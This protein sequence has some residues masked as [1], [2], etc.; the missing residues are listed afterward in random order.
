[1]GDATT[2]AD[3]GGLIGLIIFALF[4]TIGI[5]FASFKSQNKESRTFIKEIIDADRE[6]RKIDRE[7][8]LR[9]RRADRA[10]HHESFN[11]LTSALQELTNELKKK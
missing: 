4:V 9:E 10:E 11:K 5:V 8:D 2:W 3:H 1:M 7:S 6:D